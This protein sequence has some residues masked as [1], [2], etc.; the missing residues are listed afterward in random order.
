[1]K[2]RALAAAVLC[3]AVA[4]PA[5]AQTAG[6]ITWVAYSLGKPGK[7]ED[8]LKTIMKYDAPLYDKLQ[9]AGTIRSWGVATPINHRPGMKWNLLTWATLDDWGAVEKW[10]GAAMQAIQARPAAE[11]KAVQA[12]AEAS[13]E[14]RTH[15]DEVVRNAYVSTPAPGTKFAYFFVGHYVARPGQDTAATQL[16]KDAVVPMGE[17]LMAEG[18][19]AGFGLHVQELHGQFQ[20]GGT[21]WTHRVWWAVPSLASIDRIKAAQASMMTAE[22]LKRSAEVFD[23]ATH[24]DDVLMIL[25]L[26]GTPP[27]TK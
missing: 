25:H 15:F 27:A 4:G 5:V 11:A 21:V 19:V 18:V 2:A 23:M 9:S 13:E 8:W 10:A 7:T 24:W 26:G 14:T 20:P 22:N 6:P 17:K 16:Y 3:V 1:M 12:A